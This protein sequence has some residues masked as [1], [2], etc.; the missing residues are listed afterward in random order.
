MKNIFFVVGLAVLAA[1]YLVTG[2][3]VDPLF[4]VSGCCKSRRSY[5]ES[6]TRNGLNFSACKRQNDSNDRDDVFRQSGLYWWDQRC[7]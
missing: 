5:Q 6:W 7:Q 4:A 3:A 1:V 2:F